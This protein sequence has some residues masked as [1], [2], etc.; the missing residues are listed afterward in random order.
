MSSAQAGTF[1]RTSTTG[2]GAIGAQGIIGLTVGH[3]IVLCLVVPAGIW[4]FDIG[5]CHCR[6]WSA[7]SASEPETPWVSRRACSSPEPETPY[8]PEHFGVGGSPFSFPSWWQT[9]GF[10]PLVISTLNFAGSIFVLS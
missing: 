1:A 8:G 4:L 5:P 2:G 9:P 10:S 6:F 7:M 3:L